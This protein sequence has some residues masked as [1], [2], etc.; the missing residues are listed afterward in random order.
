[1]RSGGEAMRLAILM[2]IASP[3]S[4]E[5]ALRLSELGHEIHIITFRDWNS[6]DSYLR[7]DDHFQASD[8]QRLRNSLAGV[9]FLDSRLHSGLR[10]LLSAPTLRK[11]LRRCGADALLTLYAGGQ[12]AMAFASGFRPYA[13]YTVGS[14]VLKISRVKRKIARIVFR[15]ADCIFVNGGYLTQETRALAPLTRLIPLY[16]GVDTTRFSP[17]PRAAVPVNIICTRGFSPVYNNEYLIHAL[18]LMPDGLKEFSVTFASAGPL[19]SRARR[20]ADEL[21]PPRIRAKVRFLGGVSRECL[22]ENVRRSHIYVSVS[23]SDGA[24][25]SLLEALACGLFPVLSDIPQ[26]REWINS[27]ARNGMLIPLDQ[28]ETLATA[29]QRAITDEHGRTQVAEYNRN[30][31]LTRASISRNMAILAST[32]ESMINQRAR[33]RHESYITNVD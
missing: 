32:L 28:P 31:V 4:R 25:I 6:S 20:L 11:V 9:H 21:L 10:Y 26:N 19:L 33:I 29:L 13:V 23:R 24:S 27:D 22:V 5:A 12:A 17:G 7:T 3:W 2:S 14:D 1:M 30:L 16:L 8:I 18:T 15:S